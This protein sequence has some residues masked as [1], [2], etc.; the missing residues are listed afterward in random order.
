MD[1]CSDACVENFVECTE[2]CGVNGECQIECNR[3]MI[4]CQQG[5]PTI[6]SRLFRI[7]QLV[8]VQVVLAMMAATTVTMP[9]ASVKTWSI[10]RT[11][12]SVWLKLE[13]LLH[14][15]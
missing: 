9:S 13:I 1:R 14:C 8:P 10:M 3:H 12:R 7:I 4:S 6:T 11:I 15:A 5:K 2:A